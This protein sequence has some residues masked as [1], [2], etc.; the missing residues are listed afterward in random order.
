MA[1]TIPVDV[2][3]S[4]KFYAQFGGLTRSQQERVIAAIAKLDAQ[5][6]KNPLPFRKSGGI[7]SSG[8]RY[9]YDVPPD[10]AISLDHWIE[11]DGRSRPVKRVVR[12]RQI[13]KVKSSQA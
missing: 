1:P 9:L 13:V 4:D 12:L 6:W 5:D 11:R 7:F 2:F 8:R 3:R 10:L